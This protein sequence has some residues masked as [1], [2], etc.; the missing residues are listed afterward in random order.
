MKDACG[1]SLDPPRPR[2][3][4]H[5]AWSKAYINLS[6]WGGAIQAGPKARVVEVW[7]RE[8]DCEPVIGLKVGTA[9][10]T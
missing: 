2:L 10:T 9:W 1:S 3:T 4:S 7:A 5:H 6:L 8:V